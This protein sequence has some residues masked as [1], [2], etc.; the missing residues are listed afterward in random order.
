[1]KAIAPAN[2]TMPPSCANAETPASVAATTGPITVTGGRKGRPAASSSTATGCLGANFRMSRGSSTRSPARGWNR[3]DWE[4]LRPHYPLT[5][6]AWV[7]RLEANREASIA[8]AGAPAYLVWRMHGGNG[9]A[10]ERGLLS[11]G[12]LLAVK[13]L[14]DGPGDLPWTRWYQYPIEDRSG[15]L[16]AGDVV[17]GVSRSAVP[18]YRAILVQRCCPQRR[19]VL[20]GSAA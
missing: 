20:S 15:C 18:I 13:P 12:Q 1:M 2:H 19:S 5:L 4:D 16:A 8:T 14:A 3:F 6:R 17:P 11:V 7:R 9:Y 10:F